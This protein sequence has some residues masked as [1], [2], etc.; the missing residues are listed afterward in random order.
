MNSIEY[1]LIGLLILLLNADIV[2][3][4]RS[5]AFGDFI[6][7]LSPPL[8]LAQGEHSIS[9]TEG[10]RISLLS[11]LPSGVTGRSSF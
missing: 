1:L 2:I 10:D 5:Q 3:L 11:V 7:F 6:E 8:S 4:W 9:L